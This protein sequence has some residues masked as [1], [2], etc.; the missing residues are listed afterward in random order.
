MSLKFVLTWD[1]QVIYV[2]LYRAFTTYAEY[3]KCT[4]ATK[5]TYT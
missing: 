5:P 3:I 1:N 2:L 4:I